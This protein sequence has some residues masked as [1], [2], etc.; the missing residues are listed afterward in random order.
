MDQLMEIREI[1]D[2]GVAVTTDKLDTIEF[3][4]MDHSLPSPPQYLQVQTSEVTTTYHQST[5]L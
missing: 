2:S 5:D 1:S 3:E 4:T